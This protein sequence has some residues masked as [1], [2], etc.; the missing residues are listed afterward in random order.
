VF[1]TRHFQHSPVSAIYFR[2]AGC[3]SGIAAGF[4]F[5]N[6]VGGL[7]TESSMHFF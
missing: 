5:L 2:T 4:N 1:Y 3:G 6:P 7:G